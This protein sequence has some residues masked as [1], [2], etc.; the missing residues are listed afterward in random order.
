MDLVVIHDP[1][2]PVLHRKVGRVI[3][4]YPGADQLAFSQFI[5]TN[6]LFSIQHSCDPICNDTKLS[7]IQLQVTHFLAAFQTIPLHIDAMTF[8]PFRF[9]ILCALG[10]LLVDELHFDMHVFLIIFPPH[11]LSAVHDRPRDWQILMRKA[12][13]EMRA[14]LKTKNDTLLFV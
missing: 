13:L 4:T 3:Q 10:L 8:H 12:G 11:M 7:V 14:F 1:Q 6:K 5:R 2:S 9:I